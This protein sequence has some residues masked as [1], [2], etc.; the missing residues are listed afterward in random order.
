M[1]EDDVGHRFGGK[2]HNSWLGGQLIS[3]NL[4]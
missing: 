1:T 3:A 4:D 2:A